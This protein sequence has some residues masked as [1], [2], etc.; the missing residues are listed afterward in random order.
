VHQGWLRR[1]HHDQRTPEG[2]ALARK[3]RAFRSELRQLK[4]SRGEDAPISDWLPFAVHFGLVSPETNRLARFARAWDDSFSNV[5]GWFQRDDLW[6]RKQDDTI[7]LD[8]SAT[9]R[10]A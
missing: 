9:G 6:H 3:L 7:Q 5:K 2:D 4:A 10:Y 8:N 1:W